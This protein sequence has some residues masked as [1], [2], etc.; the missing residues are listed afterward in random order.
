[1]I[2]FWNFALCLLHRPDDGGNK[3]LWNVCHFLPGYTAQHPRRQSSSHS[4]PR[5]AE[6]R[7]RKIF[8]FILVTFCSRQ[9]SPELAHVSEPSKVCHWVKISTWI[10]ARHFLHRLLSNLTPFLPPP[11]VGNL[12][13]SC[14]HSELT[15]RRQA[16]SFSVGQRVPAFTES[17]GP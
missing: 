17:Q 7:L 14:C 9:T 8:Q 12:A 1:M 15:P 10:F 16:G 11:K 2:V 4:P 6:F 3:H 13:M 5:E